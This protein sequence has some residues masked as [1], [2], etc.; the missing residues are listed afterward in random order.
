M[1]QISALQALFYGILAALYMLLLR[2]YVDQLGATWVFDASKVNVRSYPGYMAGLAYILA[3]MLSAPC[4][5]WL[6]E[7]A[8]KVLDFAATIYIVH[9]ILCWA[10]VHF[11]TNVA[12]WVASLISFLLSSQIAEL[13]CARREMQAIPLATG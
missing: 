4:I 11:P 5:Y 13:M 12:W 6:V 3:G 9:L 1:L 2:G 7:R 10:V 8:K